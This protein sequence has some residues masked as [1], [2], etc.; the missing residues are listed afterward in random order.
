MLIDDNTIPDKDDLPDLI[1]YKFAIHFDVIPEITYLNQSIPILIAELL[2]II[3]GYPNDVWVSQQYVDE[4]LD[5]CRVVFWVFSESTDAMKRFTIW[6]QAIF[7][8]EKVSMI[9]EQLIICALED[10]DEVDINLTDWTR[11]YTSRDDMQTAIDI[12]VSNMKLL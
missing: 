9:L 10:P 1:T 11:I 8:D 7:R 4:G 2:P 5:F 6:F 12:E 3:E